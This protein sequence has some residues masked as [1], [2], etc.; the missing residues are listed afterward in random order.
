[1]FSLFILK[2]SR[3]IKFKEFFPVSHWD[4]TNFDCQ[5]MSITFFTIFAVQ[6]LN[7]NMTRY[8]IT[9]VEDD[10]VNDLLNVKAGIVSI[11]DAKGYIENEIRNVMSKGILPITGEPVFFSNTFDKTYD[12]S[13]IKSDSVNVC[14]NHECE[15]GDDTEIDGRV[16]IFIQQV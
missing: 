8:I 3:E 10:R 16:L 9:T 15:F 14:F 12:N 13:K 1:M 7:N 11:S 4:R 5:S 2:C 6:T